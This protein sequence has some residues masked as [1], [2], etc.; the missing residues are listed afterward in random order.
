M[1][2]DEFKK[3]CVE[4]DSDE[5]D[6]LCFEWLKEKANDFGRDGHKA[7]ELLVTVESLLS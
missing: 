5:L 7:Q 2:I 4:C 6:D 3:Q 1:T